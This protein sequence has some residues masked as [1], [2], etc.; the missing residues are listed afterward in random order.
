M[1]AFRIAIKM[2]K[3]KVYRMDVQKLMMKM[4][5][6]MDFLYLMDIFQKMR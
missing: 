6:K 4:K 1:K 2:M 3:M 5:V